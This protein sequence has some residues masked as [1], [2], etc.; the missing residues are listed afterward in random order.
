MGI[1]MS[2]GFTREIHWTI[3]EVPDIYLRDFYYEVARSTV[4]SHATVYNVE[5][6]GNMY[7]ESMNE[8]F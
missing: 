3:D 8:Y 7:K 5:Y 1:W 2:N 4:G 6:Y